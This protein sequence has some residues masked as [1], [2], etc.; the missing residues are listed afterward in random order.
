MGESANPSRRLQGGVI[1]SLALVLDHRPRF[2]HED[3]DDD[4]YEIR[5]RNRTHR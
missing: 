3:E 1:A 2:E 5:Q 4:E